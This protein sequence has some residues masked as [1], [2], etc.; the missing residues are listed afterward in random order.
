MHAGRLSPLL[1]LALLSGCFQGSGHLETRS[2]ALDGFDEIDAGRYVDVEVTRGDAF[3]VSVTADD[4]LWQALDVHR[5]GQ[6]LFFALS[7]A[8]PA[9]EGITLHAVVTMPALARLDLHG[10]AHASLVGFDAVAPVLRVHG[11]GGSTVEG[12]ARAQDLSIELSGTSHALLTGGAETLTIDGSGESVADLVGVEARAVD[13]SLSGASR[14]V[15]TATD[16]LDYHLSGD[17]HLEYAGAP[18][19]GREETSGTSTAS[20]R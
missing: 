7:D 19:L 3:A 11:S 13:V 16:R 2:F 14:G 18:Q 17:S 12:T 10:G 6:T 4:N 1:L 9:Y 8:H 20:R 5:D 15:V